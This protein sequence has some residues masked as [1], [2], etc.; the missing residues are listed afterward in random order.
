MTMTA[1]A[2]SFHSQKTAPQKK[3]LINRERSEGDIL[4]LQLMGTLLLCYHTASVFT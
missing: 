3:I 4:A 2:H 1:Q